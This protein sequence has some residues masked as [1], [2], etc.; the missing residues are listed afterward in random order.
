MLLFNLDKYETVDFLN[1]LCTDFSQ[2]LGLFF[3][4]ITLRGTTENLQEI[5]NMSAQLMSYSRSL[6]T[7]FPQ[8]VIYCIS[9]NK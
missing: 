8:N 1:L 7:E 5:T 6:Q 3:I 4:H 2:F 9:I